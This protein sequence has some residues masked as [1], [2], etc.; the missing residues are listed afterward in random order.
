MA[1]NDFVGTWRVGSSGREE[2]PASTTSMSSYL[3]IVTTDEGTGWTFT[4]SGNNQVLPTTNTQ[5]YQDG[6]NNGASRIYCEVTIGGRAFHFEAVLAINNALV[7]YGH[8]YPR[9]LGG[10]GAVGGWSA[11]KQ[12]TW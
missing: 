4:L 12:G 6:G 3:S 8:L 11:D 2:I 9:D 10:E 5:H 1:L 7:L